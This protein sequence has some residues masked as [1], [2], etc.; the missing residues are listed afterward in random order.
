MIASEASFLFFMYPDWT[1]TG[2]CGWATARID[3]FGCCTVRTYRL[4]RYYADCLQQKETCVGGGRGE[5]GIPST[6]ALGPASGILIELANGNN[7][8]TVETATSLGGSH[9]CTPTAAR[10]L[11]S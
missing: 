6:I 11:S 4:R 10:P 1:L 5:R 8:R 3:Q 2:L 9:C 7:I